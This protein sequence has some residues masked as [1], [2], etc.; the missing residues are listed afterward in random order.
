MQ[1]RLT[2]NVNAFLQTFCNKSRLKS[3]DF[4]KLNIKRKSYYKLFSKHLNGE[5]STRT[6]LISK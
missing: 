6:T 2:L 5:L 3:N 1:C 4:E